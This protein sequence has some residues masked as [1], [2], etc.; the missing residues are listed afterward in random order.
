MKDQ[1][2]P[3]TGSEG[4]FFEF[5]PLL[6]YMVETLTAGNNGYRD[7]VQR[8]IEDESV[9]NELTRQYRALT[10]EAWKI[11]VT[12]FA[13]NAELNKIFL[14]IELHGNAENY[15]DPVVIIEQ[16]LC[17]AGDISYTIHTQMLPE[18]IRQNLLE[19]KPS[20]LVEHQTTKIL[21]GAGVTI[22]SFEDS[23]GAT[24]TTLT[25]LLAP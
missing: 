6:R 14:V 12:Q 20:R 18:T 8:C 2:E 22:A 4:Q 23:G 17:E 3:D 21:D 25:P 10:G 19:Q 16:M 13:D 7:M 11:Q 5:A 1:P 9:R 24:T 15:K